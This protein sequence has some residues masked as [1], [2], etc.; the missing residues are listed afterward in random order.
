MRPACAVFALLLV[1]N[2][3][4]SDADESVTED[5]TIEPTEETA[6][7]DENSPEEPPTSE[8]DGREPTLELNPPKTS[9]PVAPTTAGTPIGG[10]ERLFPGQI[11]PGLSPFIDF[12]IADLAMRLDVDQSE[13]ETISATLVTW[14]D[15]G[16]G[17]P[18]PG[19]EYAQVL[20]DGSLIE[21]GHGAKIYRYHS[22]GDRTPFLCDQP[23][24]APPFTGGAADL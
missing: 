20:Q 17:C 13:I 7:P 4:G 1:V 18:L 2:A 8:Q 19:M 11:E 21:L 10:E 16:M 14:S 6:M 5:A 23:L 3:C 12:A 9:G 22:G 24:A 15:A